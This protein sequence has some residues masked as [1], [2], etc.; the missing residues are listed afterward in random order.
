MSEELDRAIE[1]LDTVLGHTES[2]PIA[3]PVEIEEL[4]LKPGPTSTAS[5]DALRLN[6]SLVGQTKEPDIKHPTHP[7]VEVKSQV[8]PMLFRGWTRVLARTKKMQF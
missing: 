4:E 1:K 8:G 7:F 6:P 3:S 2:R 5:S